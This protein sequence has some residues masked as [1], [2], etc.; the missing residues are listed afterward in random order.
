MEIVNCEIIKGSSCCNKS[1]KFSVDSK[2][3]L[4]E[5]GFC[6]KAV[7]NIFN[8]K[9]LSTLNYFQPVTVFNSALFFQNCP[10]RILIKNLEIVEQITLLGIRR[11]VV[12]WN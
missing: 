1:I 4:V 11:G 10:L 3:T 9:K 2:K 7:A 8:K 12:A 5:C 6:F